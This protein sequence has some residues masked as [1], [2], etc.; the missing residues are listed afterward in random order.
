M[1]RDVRTLLLAAALLWATTGASLLAATPNPVA[2][3]PA[4]GEAGR[5]PVP[6]PEASELAMSYYRSG[7]VWW[8]IQS[9]WGFVVLGA[10]LWSGASAWLR[11]HAQRIGRKWFFTLALYA[12]GFTVAT[13]LIDMPLCYLYGYA[14][15]HAY[16]LSNQT[17]G[18]W[19]G[20][21]LTSLGVS[22]IMTS[23]VVWV[24]YLLLRKVPRSW[25]LITSACAV[26]F[27]VL[28]LLVQ[29]IWIDPLYNE[30]GPMKDPKL[31]KDI[32]G[33]AS[34]AG[35]E[36]GRVF[37][38]RKSVDTKA[39]NAYVTGFRETKRIVLWDTLI[40]KL[41]RDE[42]LFVMAHEMGHY[43]L[44]HTWY[45]IAL[46]SVVVFAAL[47]SIHRGAHAVIAR[48][49]DRFGFSELSDIASLPLLLLFFQLAVFILLPPINAVSR[50]FEHEADRFGLEIRRDGHSAATAFVK[51]QQENLSNP[52][53][54]WVHRLWRASHPSLGDRI[55]FCNTYR[56]WA[57]GQPLRYGDR[58]RAQR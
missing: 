49:R 15:E 23:L 37:E 11:T 53:P 55:E 21:S 42:V 4:V 5:P 16:G 8:G 41:D 7:M 58:F 39:V 38:V 54:G 24:P 1:I 27:I 40:A 31:E 18:K 17:L 19:F 32:L 56:P 34:R 45:L 30:Y 48:F 13:W 57:E 36:G 28:M 10:I 47:F 26:P 14:R 25:W 20:D 52:R 12:A 46:M 43:V 3:E 35:I 2:A 33:L 29:P 22:V 51:L 50:Y 6:V 9:V 44:G